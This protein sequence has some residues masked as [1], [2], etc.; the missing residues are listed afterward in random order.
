[1]SEINENEQEILNTFMKKKS[2]G[3]EPPVD[4]D[5]EEMVARWEKKKQGKCPRCGNPVKYCSCPEDDF[6]S[7]VNSYRI[8]NEKKIKVESMEIKKFSSFIA[9]GLNPDAIQSLA[10]E[11]EAEV[12]DAVS[13][14]ATVE[15]RSTKKTWDDGV[16]VLKYIARAPIE[17]VKLPKKFKVVDDEKYGWWYFEINGKWYGIEKEAYGTPPFEY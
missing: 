4:K 13:T 1:M 11:L 15:A 3:E 5:S 12:Y 17:K 7:T 9:E 6:Y 2:T 8:P 14:G 16:P 10:K